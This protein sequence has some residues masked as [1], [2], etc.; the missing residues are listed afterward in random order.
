MKHLKILAAVSALLLGAFAASAQKSPE[1]NLQHAIRTGSDLLVKL[2]QYYVDSLNVDSL[3]H[4]GMNYAM[5]GLD[6]YTEYYSAEEADRFRRDASGEYGGIGIRIATYNGQGY[7]T[8]PMEGM[9][10]I[11]AGLRS[12]DKIIRVDTIDTRGR[13]GDFIT[14]HLRGQAGTPVTI[15]VVRPYAPDSVITVT[16]ERAKIVVPAVSYSAILPGHIGYI[17]LST[18]SPD[19]TA[20][21]VRRVLEGF[22]ADK[23]LKG[24]I[25]DLKDN[26]GGLLSQAVE[27]ASMFLP[28]GS[29]IIE[30]R[31][32]DGRLEQVYKTRQEPIFPDIPL[33]V[34]INR[35]SASASELFAG[36]LQDY[37]R[38][39]LIGE[40]SFGKGLV[41]STLP[42]PYD[43]MLKL[44]T[45]KYYIPSGRLIQ[46]L[47]YSHRDESG[48][49][50]YTPDSLAKTFYTAAGRRVKDG[51][52]LQPELRVNDTI[53]HQ[54]LIYNLLSSHYMFDYANRRYA[55]HQGNAPFT[56]TDEVWEEFVTTLPDTALHYESRLEKGLMELKRVAREEG[57]MN[58]ATEAAFAGLSKALQRDARQELKQARPEIERFLVPMLAERYG[59]ERAAT[60]AEVSFDPAVRAA[61]DLLA[62]PAEYHRLLRKQ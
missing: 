1:T 15:T 11:K 39:V 24:I 27:I 42:M 6:P 38:A 52:G 3:L 21:Q 28:K 26:G 32:R 17:A 36:A 50:G 49:P 9:P 19:D 8:D 41:Q 60:A 34:L 40:R 7:F 29:K 48:H 46:A 20:E 22:K 13:N 5:A 51:G 62:N 16:I 33:A 54:E 10:A 14:K 44:T 30:A 58:E 55:A 31:G 53:A 25:F 45:A 43:G 47:D 57:S 59:F 35:G 18:F 37:D 12:G 56:M 23:E 61:L 2:Q 4:L